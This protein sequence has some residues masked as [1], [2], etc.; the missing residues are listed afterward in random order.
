MVPWPGLT[1]QHRSGRWSLHDAI[2]D[3]EAKTGAVETL[4]REEGI[5]G[6]SPHIVGHSDLASADGEL[7]SIGVMARPGGAIR[8]TEALGEHA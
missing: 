7:L 6:A 5:E 1:R 3:G 4:G 8:G 2:H